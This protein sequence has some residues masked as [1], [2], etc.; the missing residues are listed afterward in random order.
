MSVSHKYLRVV[1]MKYALNYVH[2][3]TR[4]P[5]TWQNNEVHKYF[6]GMCLTGG[7]LE[8]MLPFILI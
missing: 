3:L 6:K 5:Y 8:D 4:M 7:S 2:V 1:L